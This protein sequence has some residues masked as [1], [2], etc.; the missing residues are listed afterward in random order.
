MGI[1]VRLKYF[2]KSSRGSALITALFVMALIAAAATALAY[3][4]VLSIQNANQNFNYSQALQY[5]QTV[6]DWA[7][8]LLEQDITNPTTFPID[9]IPSLYPEAPVNA[10]SYR[11]ILLDMQAKFNLNNLVNPYQRAGFTNM[12]KIILP[13]VQDPE[14]ITNA[15]SNYVSPLW[16]LHTSYDEAYQKDGLNYLPPHRL[17]LNVVELRKV[18]GIN[19]A[20]YQQLMPY[21]TVLP[22]ANTSLNINTASPEVLLSLGPN[23]SLEAAHAVVEARPYRT[24]ADI[25]ASP[26]L[27]NYNLSSDSLTTISQFFIARSLVTLDHQQLLTNNYLYRDPLNGKVD[28]LWQTQGSSE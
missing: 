9:K 19:A 27:K 14:K 10:G 4:L 17:M 25:T 16:Q 18:I 28:V 6:T 23:I 15:I 1:E 11:G 26:T 13:N 22:R 3:E 24:H 20:I 8:D 2:K 5:N 21:V 7:V 12:L